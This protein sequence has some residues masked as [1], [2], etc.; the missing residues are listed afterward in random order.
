MLGIQ[1][2]PAAGF[3]LLLF[4]IPESP[5]WLVA[6]GRSDEARLVLARLGASPVELPA[7]I[8]AM[9]AS[10]DY[11]HHGLEE[12]FLQRA[13][14]RP[15]L[16]AVAIAAFNQLSG[17]NAVMYYAPSIFRMAGAATQSAL[18]QS[19]IV[20]GTNL[21]FTMAAMAVID[22]FGRRRLMLVGSIGYIVSLGTLAWAF[23]RY[24]AAF[25]P[26]GSQVVLAGLLVFIA[27]HA[28]GQGAV[29]WVLISEIFPN[30]I[31]ARAVKRSGHSFTG[32]WP[33]SSPGP[34][35]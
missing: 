31:R 19:V 3:F 30:R 24:G 35:R 11:D 12:R 25:T 18:L 17:I 22:R 16:L 29:I 33:R 32:S 4:R 27:A 1:A 28:F 14:R 15:I 20:G 10:L 26:A 34:S 7:Q 23:Y 9:R 5:R 8:A 21:V 2:V 6:R 13:Y